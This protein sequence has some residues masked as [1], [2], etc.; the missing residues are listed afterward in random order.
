MNI[1]SAMR[2]GESQLIII[3]ASANTTT[4]TEEPGKSSHLA[5]LLGNSKT[6]Q[7]TFC[8]YSDSREEPVLFYMD[9]T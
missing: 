2:V 4:S 1:L 7:S 3:D 9:V 5:P 6:R 8:T